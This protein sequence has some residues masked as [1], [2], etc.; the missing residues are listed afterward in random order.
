M[1]RLGSTGVPMQLHES[2]PGLQ[3]KAID[4]VRGGMPIFVPFKFSTVAPNLIR[5]GESPICVPKVVSKPWFDK[6]PAEVRTMIEE[7]AAKADD[8]NIAWNVE[9]LGRLYKAWNAQKGVTHELSPAEKAD[10][11]KRLQTV[12]DDVFKDAPQVKATYEALKA[13]AQRT[14]K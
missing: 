7:E 9:N 5:T 2:L 3:Q 6:L 4:G 8:A 10:L 11:R 12:G 14:R 13:A 1:R